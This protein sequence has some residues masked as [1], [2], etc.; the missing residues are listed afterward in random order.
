MTIIIKMTHNSRCEHSKN[1]KCKCSCK[2]RYHGKI[3]FRKLDNWFNDDLD[4]ER[5]E[6][7]VKKASRAIFEVMIKNNV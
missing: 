4:K 3:T 6:E 1:K 5:G 7:F 2:G